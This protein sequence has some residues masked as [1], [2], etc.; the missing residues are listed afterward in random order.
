MVSKIWRSFLWGCKGF[1]GVIQGCIGT[2]R[3][4]GLGCPKLLVLEGYYPNHEKEIHKNMDMK[5]RPW[6]YVLPS[7][8]A[9]CQGIRRI[10][11]AVFG[12]IPEIETPT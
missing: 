4:W 6:L 9:P 5:W 2:H 8:A 3:I 11:S 10:R 12:S 7:A 1:I